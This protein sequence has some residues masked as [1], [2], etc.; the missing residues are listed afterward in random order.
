L[1]PKPLG[2]HETNLSRAV[3]SGQVE[4]PGF[5]THG[6]SQPLSTS[7]TFETRVGVF[8]K[9][10]PP[11]L[12][13]QFDHFLQNGAADPKS[14][15]GFFFSFCFHIR[16]VIAPGNRFSPTPFP[17]SLLTQRSF[18]FFVPCSSQ[19]PPFHTDPASPNNSLLHDRPFTTFGRVFFFCGE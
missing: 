4:T 15:Y 9:H 7:W 19:K 11:Y 2:R 18:F 16:T 5:S 10:L 17:F 1:H 12:L 8:N 14:G 3:Y 6:F 13:T